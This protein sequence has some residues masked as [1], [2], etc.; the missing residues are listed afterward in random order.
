MAQSDVVRIAKPRQSFSRAIAPAIERELASARHCEARGDAP[1]AFRRLE[2]AHVLGQGA[3]RHHA[4]VHV[5]M[6]RWAL[7]RRHWREVTGQLL[8]LLGA[9]TKTAF[10]LVPVGNTGGANVAVFK[11]MPIPPDLQAEID[12]AR[13]PV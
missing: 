4:R 2:R 10:G 5:A 9:A 6:L 1:G 12:A 13:R 11:R 8:R 3:T 7:R